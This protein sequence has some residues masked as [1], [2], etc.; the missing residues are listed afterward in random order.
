MTMTDTTPRAQL[1][2]LLAGERSMN[3]VER[4]A[5]IGAIGSETLRRFTRL[6]AVSTATEHPY[7]RRWG[8]ERWRARRDRTAAAVS[9]YVL[10]KPGEWHVWAVCAGSGNT[11][12]YDDDGNRVRVMIY[13]AQRYLSGGRGGAPSGEVHPRDYATEA[14]A[15]ARCDALNAA[16]AAPIRANLRNL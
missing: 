15:Q 10:G 13:G 12:R 11:W 14:E 2:Q 7:T 9:A 1:R 4:L 16:G 8:L 5:R 3:E 6:W